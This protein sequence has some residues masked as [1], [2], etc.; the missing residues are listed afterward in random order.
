MPSVAEGRTFLDSSKS[1][2]FFFFLM[3]AADNKWIL[4]SVFLS[5]IA[6]CASSEFVHGGIHFLS[7]AVNRQ[8]SMSIL[9]NSPWSPRR[10]Q[11]LETNL[12]CFIVSQSC[13]YKKNVYTLFFRPTS[14][15]LTQ[16]N[17]LIIMTSSL[18]NPILGQV[19]SWFVLWFLPPFI[20]LALFKQDEGQVY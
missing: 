9:F 10:G 6:S 7:H 2:F 1:W 11:A 16:F 17:V 15:E 13:C 19:R 12:L 3:H 20:F 14:W 4:F 18:T 8:V 5:A